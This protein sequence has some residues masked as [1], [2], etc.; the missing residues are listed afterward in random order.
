MK[1][2]FIK[3]LCMVNKHRF[4]VFK[5]CTKCGLFWRGLIHDLSKFSPIEFFE[6][7]RYYSG[8]YSPN[9]LCR[10]KNGYS[11]AWLH[12]KGRNK[13]HEDYWVD[14]KNK[15]PIDIP[16]KYAVEGICDK[17]AASKC[18]NRKNHSAQKVLD[19]WL[20][21]EKRK[22]INERMI[23]F[24][25]TVLMHLVEKGEKE[26]LNRKYLKKTYYDIVKAKKQDQQPQ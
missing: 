16:Y 25:D 11:Y 6:G 9:T 4:I 21:S 8:R 5:L 19:Y 3:H 1:H 15:E 18:Y 13:H 24:F 22:I 14:R 7:V 17:I 23:N 26:T 20:T 2:K 12:H 10:R